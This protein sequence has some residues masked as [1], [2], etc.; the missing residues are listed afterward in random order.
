MADVFIRDD[1]S[2]DDSQAYYKVKIKKAWFRGRDVFTERLHY[3]E[4][5]LIRNPVVYIPLNAGN[6]IYTMMHR[7]ETG[8]EWEKQAALMASYR[9]LVYRLSYTQ[10]SWHK[11][12]AQFIVFEGQKSDVMW[13]MAFITQVFFEDPMLCMT[14]PSRPDEPVIAF[15]IQNGEYVGKNAVISQKTNALPDI[16]STEAAGVVTDDMQYDPTHE[17]QGGEV[18][19][20]SDG[21]IAQ[22]VR[23]DERFYHANRTGP[24]TDAITRHNISASLIKD[25]EDLIYSQTKTAFDVYQLRYVAFMNKVHDLENKLG[26]LE[27]T[28]YDVL[29]IAERGLP[30]ASVDTISRTNAL[31]CNSLKYILDSIQRD[32]ID[33]S[34]RK[35]IAKN[36]ARSVSMRQKGYEDEYRMYLATGTPENLA[37]EMYKRMISELYNDFARLDAIRAFGFSPN[38]YR[39]LCNVPASG[40]PVMT[41]WERQRI[42]LFG[43]GYLDFLNYQI[44]MSQ[45][46]AKGRVWVE[47][48]RLLDARFMRAVRK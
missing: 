48:K 16:W 3:Y 30:L 46:K 10:V 31:D 20:I 26:G 44:K 43:K 47:A 38:I 29:P 18:F 9:N 23:M 37:A 11:D 27:I 21:R 25:F 19:A 4:K 32:G 8:V 35:M 12:D 39:D 36:A 6:M 24:K 34:E 42:R 33:E 5:Q 7:L 45:N 17:P 28:C 22:Y 40:G 41:D 2:L 1:N 15:A 14:I 13:S